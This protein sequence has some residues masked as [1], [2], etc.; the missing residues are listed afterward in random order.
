MYQI[1][2]PSGKSKWQL[3]IRYSKSWTVLYKSHQKIQKSCAFW[4]SKVF[5]SAGSF[6]IVIAG[7]C[8]FCSSGFS[9]RLLEA[10]AWTQFLLHACYIIHLVNLSSFRSLADQMSLLRWVPAACDHPSGSLARFLQRLGMRGTKCEGIQHWHCCLSLLTRF[11]L[12]RGGRL[13][14]QSQ[15]WSLELWGAGGRGDTRHCNIPPCELDQEHFW[16]HLG[17]LLQILIWQDQK[18][19]YID[20]CQDRASSLTLKLSGLGGKRVCFELDNKLCCHF[21]GTE[22]SP[23]VS[24]HYWKKKSIGTSC[25]EVHP[26]N[27]L[28]WRG[29]ANVTW[30]WRW[31]PNFFQKCFSFCLFNRKLVY[32]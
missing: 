8:K 12:Q 15:V 28:Y 30:L 31:I 25:M 20:F 17:F 18:C 7:R 5:L 24:Q 3:C 23:Y 29:P 11:Q 32:A 10:G 9:R 22:C 13:S 6:R 27:H 19:W 4:L 2:Y 21:P 26:N 1:W 14:F 16:T